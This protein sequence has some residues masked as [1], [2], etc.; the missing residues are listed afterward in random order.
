M[1]ASKTYKTTKIIHKIDQV[2]LMASM[3]TVMYEMNI[4]Y[5][6]IFPG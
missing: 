3:L 1:L 2:G 6:D 5:P 4:T